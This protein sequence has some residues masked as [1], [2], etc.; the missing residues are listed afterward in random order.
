MI[1][2]RTF[3]GFAPDGH[4]DPFPETSRYRG[5]GTRRLVDAQGNEIVYVARRIVPP[6]ERFAE[7]GQVEVKDGDRIDMIAAEQIGDPELYW[8]LAD[9]N[10]ALH[11]AQLTEC[12]GR[13]LRVTLPEGLLGPDE[14][15]GP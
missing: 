15:Y 5:L 11:P 10:G 3:A 8:H 13:K 4:S 9:A 7:I 2:P 12:T 1:D 6:P 14:E